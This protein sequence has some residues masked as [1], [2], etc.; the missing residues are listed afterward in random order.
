[1][2]DTSAILRLLHSVRRR[3]RGN[4]MLQVLVDG[5]SQALGVFLVLTLWNTLMPEAWGLGWLFYA[6]AA[7]CV[8]GVQLVRLGAAES[9]SSTAHRTDG[10]ADLHDELVSAHWF[11]G[12]QEGDEWVDLHLSRATDTARGLSAE[13]LVPWRRPRGVAVPVV[14]AVGLMAVLLLPVPRVFEDIAERLGELALGGGDEL[15][16]E[17]LADLEQLG[18]RAPDPE[19]P[20]EDEEN[21]LIPLGEQPEASGENALPEEEGTLE[22]MD[23][24]EGEMA[25]GEEAG[26][27]GEQGEQ[28]E[29]E[30][31]EAQSPEDAPAEQ[32]GEA[33]PDP[34][35]GQDD[36]EGESSEQEGPMLPG[37]EEVFLQEGGEDA[38]QQQLAEEEMG[39]ATREGGGEEELDPGELTTLEV[40]LERELLGVPEEEADPE[41]EDKEELVTRAERSFLEYEEISPPD[42]FAV[43]ELLQSE[44]IPWRYRQLVLNYFKVLRERDNQ[45]QEQERE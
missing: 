31:Q 10:L 24:P 21:A 8:V 34:S 22:E 29:G 11:S 27:E 2:P 20:P 4:R 15:A 35:A 5:G 16:D 37:G 26:A 3:T 18:D 28:T 42:A 7:L 13:R 14:L 38:E 40:Q 43:Q 19:A 23:E 45:Q 12:Q 30:Q 32:Q 36:G 6:V 1:M 39:H 41:S 44:S 9:L 25:E 33:S 17:P